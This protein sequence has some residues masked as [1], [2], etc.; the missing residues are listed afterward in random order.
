MELVMGREKITEMPRPFFPS[1]KIF[2]FI[3]ICSY[4]WDNDNDNNKLPEKRCDVV[5]NTY[6]KDDEG[7]L[8]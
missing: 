5:W 4:F 8:V 3:S 1:G 6:F 2:Q 7:R